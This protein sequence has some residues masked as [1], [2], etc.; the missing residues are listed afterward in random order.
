MLEVRT[1]IEADDLLYDSA[2]VSHGFAPY[3]RDYDAVFER[4]APRPGRDGS[5]VSARYRVRF[6]HCVQAQVR[7]RKRPDMLRSSWAD[8]RFIDIDAWQAAG[9]PDGLLWGLCWQEAYPG[10]SYVADST[11]LDAGESPLA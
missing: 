7:V 9:S 3:L 6:I 8:D 1:R 11:E 2:V 4:S 10:M 5:Y